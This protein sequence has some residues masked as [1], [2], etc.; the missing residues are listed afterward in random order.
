MQYAEFNI[1]IGPYGCHFYRFGQDASKPAVLLIHG[2]IGNG[3]IFYSQSGKGYAPWLANQGFD[4][5]VI[6]LP[7]KGKSKPKISAAFEQS[8]T[9][10]VDRDIPAI[11]EEVQRRNVSGILHIGAHSFGGVWMAAALARKSI[12]VQSMVFFGCKRRISIFS[13]RRLLMVD[14]IWTVVGTTAAK[15]VGYLPAKAMRMGSDNEPRD[16]FLQTNKWVYQKQWIDPEDGLNYVHE[17]GQR[18]IPPTLFLTGIKDHVLGN[19]IDVAHLKSE[20][21]PTDSEL[22]ILGKNNGNLADYNH[23]NILTNPLAHEDHFPVTA[24]WFRRYS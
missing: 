5:F 7:G 23:V 21:N 11:V 16:F 24:D 12:A 6:D 3:R 17:L 9:A 2:A 15:I 8:Q 14:V 18:S 1:N 4:V 22:I 13:L 10:F 20:M 19:P